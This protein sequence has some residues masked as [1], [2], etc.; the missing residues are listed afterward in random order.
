VTRPFAFAVAVA[1]GLAGAAVMVIELAGAHV[2][3]PGF[4]IGLNA[5]A[6]MITVALGGLAGGYFLGGVAADRWRG[7]APRILSAAL[8]AGGAFCVADALFWEKAVGAFTRLGPRLGALGAA[9]V[10]FLLPFIALGAVFPLAVKLRTRAVEEVGRRTGSLSA[11]SAVGSLLGAVLAWFWLVPSLSIE[12]TFAGCAAVL[13]MAAA[14]VLIAARGPNRAGIILLLLS[15]G[16]LFV[17]AGPLPEGVLLRRGSLF[18]PLEVRQSG[19]LRYLTVAN[20]VQGIARGDPVR[21]HMPHTRLI[22]QM[23]ARS[24]PHDGGKVLLIGLGAGFIPRE[25][26]PIPCETV[27]I[28]PAIVDAATRFFAFD[29]ARHPVHVADGR[30]FLLSTRER[31]EAVV[32]DALRGADMPFHLLTREFF[33]LVRR[34][35]HPG[36]ILVVNYQGFLFGSEGLLAR[37]VEKTLRSVFEDVDIC[38]HRDPP[39]NAVAIFAAHGPDI[40]AEWSPVRGY[41]VRQTFLADELPAR[42][43][44]DSR[45]PVELWSAQLDCRRRL[46]R[47]P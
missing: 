36:G 25:L 18:G 9:A 45:N 31:Y 40:F 32:I 12:T 15:C 8:A 42:I 10:L 19:I 47:A 39:E 17:S 2:L 28:D 27:E 21:S 41:Q 35:L 11:V 13:V 46:S 7:H 44:T 29:P 38:F 6:A 30:A 20:T 26:D 5:W 22:S 23:L 16:P 4:G 3:A 33:E 24:I 43:L 14:A 1:A 37:S 34:R